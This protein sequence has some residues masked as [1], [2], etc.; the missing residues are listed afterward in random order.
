MESDSDKSDKII[1]KP[2][3]PSTGLPVDRSEYIMIRSL[4]ISDETNKNSIIINSSQPPFKVGRDKNNNLSIASTKISNY[5]CEIV[6]YD[7]CCFVYDKGS[8][9]GTFIKLNV[10]KPIRLKTNMFFEIGNS[11]YTFEKNKAK[12][13]LAMK[14]SDGIN[15]GKM[16]IELNPSNTTDKLIILGKKEKTHE[17]MVFLNDESLDDEHAIIIIKEKKFY[18]LA[19]ESKNG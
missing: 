5:Q 19:L 15:I 17:N 10:L 9:N 4:L 1:A 18:L 16:L 2:P 14:A 12:K 3:P 13:T 6:A 11:L 8:L 7:D